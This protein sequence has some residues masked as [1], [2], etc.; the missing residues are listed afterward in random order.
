MKRFWDK[1]NVQ[2]PDDCWEWQASTS[3]DG[4]GQVQKDGKKYGTHRMAYMLS[5]GEIPAGMQV[6]HLCHNKLC[7][8]PNHLEAQTTWQNNVERFRAGRM[9]AVA[10]LSDWQVKFIVWLKSQEVRNVDIAKAVECEPYDVY[11]VCKNWQRYLARI[12]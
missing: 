6:A 4:Y 8:N 1:A 12:A 7:C 2:G 9:G 5:K 10:K 11:N 3:G